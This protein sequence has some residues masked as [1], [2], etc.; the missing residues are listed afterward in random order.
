MNIVS[1]K[2]KKSYIAVYNELLVAWV[3]ATLQSMCHDI[4]H[5][6]IDH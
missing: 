2:K 1:L 5:F 3:F 6:E 4:N